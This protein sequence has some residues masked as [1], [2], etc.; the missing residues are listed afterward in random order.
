MTNG[1]FYSESQINQL[2]LL[3]IKDKMNANGDVFQLRFSKGSS[4]LED[5]VDTL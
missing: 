4:T 3:F 2:W 1:L 5:K